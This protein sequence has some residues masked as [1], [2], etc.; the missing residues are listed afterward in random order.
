MKFDDNDDLK[1]VFSDFGEDLR[2]L[3]ESLENLK[4]ENKQPIYKNQTEDSIFT[5][6]DDF[7]TPSNIKK[8]RVVGKE[9][10]VAEQN[11]DADDFEISNS[12]D[13]LQSSYINDLDISQNQNQTYDEI[14]DEIS[15]SSN[16][17]YDDFEMMSIIKPKAQTYDNTPNTANNNGENQYNS[18]YAQMPS[19]TKSG[20]ENEKNSLVQDIMNRNIKKYIDGKNNVSYLNDDLSSVDKIRVVNPNNNSEFNSR[21]GAKAKKKTLGFDQIPASLDSANPTTFY[22]EKQEDEFKDLSSKSPEFEAFVQEK[23]QSKI[24][25]KKQKKD[26][27]NPLTTISI[28]PKKKDVENKTDS[29]MDKVVEKEKATQEQE[30]IRVFDPSKKRKPNGKKLDKMPNEQTNE[31]HSKSKKT[32]KEPKSQDTIKKKSNKPIKAI[33]L[34]SFGGIILLIGLIFYFVVGIDVVDIQVSGDSIY[35]SQTVISAT[36][37]QSGENI[38]RV[39]ANEIEEQ[40][41]ISLPYIEEVEVSKSFAGV[42]DVQIISCTADKYCIEANNSYF[43]LDENLKILSI[44]QSADDSVYAVNGFD[45]QDLEVGLT[46][47]AS[48]DN[49]QRISLLQIISEQLDSIEL[50]DKIAIDLADIDDV[51]IAYC[52]VSIT[53]GAVLYPANIV[54]AIE[55]V[56]LMSDYYDI[57]YVIAEFEDG[58]ITKF[59]VYDVETE[60]E[61][62]E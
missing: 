3:E 47:E 37:I 15:R 1:S 16:N 62:T 4:K 43:T 11:D 27:I 30:P 36:Q 20:K 17:T 52:N 38:L 39:S 29:D 7:E 42:V 46:Y 59:D 22:A 26:I 48:E 51:Q 44:S 56:D 28:K 55:K 32:Q 57:G 50:Q 19:L 53:L 35:D 61:T 25:E 60:D 2:E 8:F 5:F 58:V 9:P 12:S 45:Y 14:K 21:V 10:I 54:S 18:Q 41:K 40:I 13:Y 34:A 33:V 6:Q 24:N 31:K 23:K 49:E